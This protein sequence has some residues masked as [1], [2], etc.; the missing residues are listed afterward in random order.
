[1]TERATNE[2]AQGGDEAE[3]YV[4]IGYFDPLVGRRII[5]R[6]STEGVRFRAHDASRLDVASA[7]TID[8]V[9]WRYPYPITARINRIELFVHWEDLDTVRKVIDEV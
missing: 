8:Y 4:S 9:S 5:K 2:D 3:H 1:M 7:G 6:L